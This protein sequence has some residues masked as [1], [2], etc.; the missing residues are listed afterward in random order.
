MGYQMR[1]KLT[2]LIGEKCESID[3]GEKL[4]QAIH[5][6]IQAGSAVELDFTGVRSIITPFLNASIGK[7]LDLFEKET[8]MEKLIL[9]HIS[10]DHLR[11]VNEFI[12]GKQQMNSEKTTLDMMKEMFAEDDL[13]DI[14][15]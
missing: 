8:L 10:E 11:R 13:G 14:E 15:S 2:E 1:V 12:D 5:K 7:L 4:Y 6:E 9:C 3:D